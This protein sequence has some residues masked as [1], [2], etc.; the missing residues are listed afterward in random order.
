M[1]RVQGAISDGAGDHAVAEPL[2]TSDGRE[3]PR[4]VPD[5]RSYEPRAA[6]VGVLPGQVGQSNGDT[7][8]SSPDNSRH[9]DTRG[10]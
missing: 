2:G 1:D 4:R 10:E 5:L 7:D 3:Q 6:R 9:C 8:P